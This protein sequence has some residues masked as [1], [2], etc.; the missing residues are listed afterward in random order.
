MNEFEVRAIV[1]Q[2]LDEWSNAM[3]RLLGE[4]FNDLDP[5]AIRKML[6]GDV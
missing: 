4:L 1:R 6:G 3:S 5:D 2:E